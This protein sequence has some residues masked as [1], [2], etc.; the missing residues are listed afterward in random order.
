MGR[1]LMSAESWISS[2]VCA[3]LHSAPVRRSLDKEMGATRVVAVIFHFTFACR[4]SDALGIRGFAGIRRRGLLWSGCQNEFQEL[5]KFADLRASNKEGRQKAQ[6]EIVSA[7]DQQA[8]LHGFTDKRA[9][10]D[11]KFDAD[12]QAFAT[13]GTNKIEFSSKLGETSLS[14]PEPCASRIAQ[15]SGPYNI[16]DEQPARSWCPSPVAQ[17]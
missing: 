1:A 16:T 6:R 13:D 2:R 8:A 12:H 9:A 11:G 4:V 3:G 7:I 14:I 10:F 5:E 15:K 17:A